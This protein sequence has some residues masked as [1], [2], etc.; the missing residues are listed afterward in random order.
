MAQARRSL[1]PLTGAAFAILFVLSFIVSGETPGADESGEKVIALISENESKQML[2]AILGT[3]AAILFLF[4]NGSVRSTLRA[5]EGDEG[6]LSAVAFAGGIVAA[7]GML[8][9][10][11]IAFTLA[12]GV[13]DFEPGAAQALNALNAN[14]F[15]PLA[16][17]IATFQLATG[18]AAIRTGALPSWLAWTSLLIGVLMVTPLGFFA[19]LAGVVWVLVASVVLWIGEPT[20]ASAAR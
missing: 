20:T 5:A 11:G 9:F 19:F 16:G 18:L 3:V 13:S 1:L 14:F 6:T 2:G 7:T 8:I 17:G 15:F 10:S 12:E 4:F